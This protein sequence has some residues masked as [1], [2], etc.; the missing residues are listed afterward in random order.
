MRILKLTLVVLISVVVVFALVPLCLSAEPE[1]AKPE[2]QPTMK[3]VEK[4][5]SETMQ[6]IKNYSSDQ[7]DEA[8]KKIKTDLE[9]MDQRIDQ[10]ENQ[11]RTKWH[12]MDAYSREKTAETLKS[13]HEKRNEI[14]EWYGGIKHSSSPA[15]ETVKKGFIDSYNDLDGVL[16][17]AENKFMKEDEPEKKPIPED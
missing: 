4:E 10:F 2:L 7:K 12:R 8:V 6:V 14:A 9:E 1:P 17:K 13:L 15:W 16:R 5:M 11:A 3:D